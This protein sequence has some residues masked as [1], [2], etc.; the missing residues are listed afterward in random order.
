MR[1]HPV[2]LIISLFSQKK[3]GESGDGGMEELLFQTDYWE[4]LLDDIQDPGKKW[5]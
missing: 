5:P 4:D 2:S 3:Q 1:L